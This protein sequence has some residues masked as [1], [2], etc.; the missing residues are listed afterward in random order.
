MILNSMTLSLSK[1]GLNYE[2]R[3]GERMG[4][5]NSRSKN[6]AEQSHILVKILF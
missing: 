6:M 1:G 2:P 4:K 3:Y 5:L